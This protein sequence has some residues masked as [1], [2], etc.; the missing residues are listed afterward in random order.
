MSS[1]QVARIKKMIKIVSCSLVA[2]NRKL[3]FAKQIVVTYLKYLTDNR[4]KQRN[5]KNKIDQKI[6]T[7]KYKER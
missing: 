1:T 5:M 3:K 6:G 2:L 4:S 7:V